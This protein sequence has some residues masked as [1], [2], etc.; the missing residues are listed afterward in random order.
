MI[1]KTEIEE[2]QNSWGKGIITI[3]KLKENFKRMQNFYC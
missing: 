1:N 3:G 2:V